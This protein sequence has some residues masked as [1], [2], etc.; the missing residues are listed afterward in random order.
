MRRCGRGEVDGTGAIAAAPSPSA[1]AGRATAPCPNGDDMHRD[2][3]PHAN[4]LHVKDAEK[5]SVVQRQGDACDS[6]STPTDIRI[7]DVVRGS[8]TDLR[9]VECVDPRTN[10]CSLTP[11]CRLKGVFRAALLAYFK[12]LDA[13]TLADTARPVPPR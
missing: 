3:R 7:G 5:T 12:E 11:S 10:T 6:P 1:P 13:F 2:S 9:L 4:T 8:E